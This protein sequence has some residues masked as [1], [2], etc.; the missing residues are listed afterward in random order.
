M[1]EVK[2]LLARFEKILLSEENKRESVRRA[3]AE[4]LNLEIN[5]ADV[6]IKNNTVYLRL[7]PIYKNEIL[8]KQEQILGRIQELLLGQVS[9]LNLR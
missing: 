3:L 9:P 5:P 7:K 6:R 4:A 1:I 8:L 2:N